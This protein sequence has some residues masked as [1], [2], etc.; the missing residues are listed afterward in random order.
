MT[1]FSFPKRFNADD[2]E[3][4]IWFKVYDELDNFYGEYRVIYF[5]TTSPLVTAKLTRWNRE[6]KA[7]RFKGDEGVIRAFVDV[8]LLDWRD[9][10][11]GEGGAEL[12]FKKDTAFELLS[13]EGGKFLWDALFTNATSVHNFQG[14]A[15]AEAK[16]DAKK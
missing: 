4:G 16:E 9:V 11:L 12:P 8:A 2:A 6:N 13:S 3:K 10:N 1:Q 7:A 15:E 14:H 5:N